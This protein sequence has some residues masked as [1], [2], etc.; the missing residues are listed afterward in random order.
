MK[1][2]VI[3]TWELEEGSL[4]VPFKLEVEM[5]VKVGKIDYSKEEQ[6]L[7]NYKSRWRKV[8]KVLWETG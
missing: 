8:Q 4:E 1:L 2:E 6:K 3:S 5:I 7:G